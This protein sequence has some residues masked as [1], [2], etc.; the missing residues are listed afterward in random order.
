MRS[1]FATALCL[2][3]IHTSVARIPHSFRELIERDAEP[4]AEEDGI[5]RWLARL[6]K[7]DDP[8][9]DICYEDGYYEFVSGLGSDFCH[10]YLTYP[11]V[12]TTVD[13]TPTR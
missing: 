9:N 6:F 8:P 1:F 3:L 12:T 13:Y 11:N 4:E 2:S 5:L 7:R 10:E